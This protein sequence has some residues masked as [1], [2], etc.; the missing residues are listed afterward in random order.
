MSHGHPTLRGSVPSEDNKISPV[1]PGQPKVEGPLPG[2]IHGPGGWVT[3]GAPPIQAQDFTGP[4]WY[5][6]PHP[7]T[8]NYIIIFPKGNRVIEVPRQGLTGLGKNLYQPSYSLR[9]I[10]CAGY[11]CDSLGR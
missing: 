8:P 1:V 10:P 11:D 5:D 7:L 3:G 9:A 2:F 4:Q 6:T